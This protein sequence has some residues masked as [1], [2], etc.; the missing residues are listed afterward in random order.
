MEHRTQMP[1]GLDADGQIAW[2]EQ[3][4]NST[5]PGGLVALVYPAGEDVEEVHD[6]ASRFFQIPDVDRARS[7]LLLRR[8]P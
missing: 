4:R 8:R 5:P 1:E 6:R 3:L 2:L 7:A